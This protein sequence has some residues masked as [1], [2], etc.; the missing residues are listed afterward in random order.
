MEGRGAGG[1]AGFFFMCSPESSAFQNYEQQ[2]EFLTAMISQHISDFL[3]DDFTQLLNSDP[4][5]FLE[6]LGVGKVNGGPEDIVYVENSRKIFGYEIDPR[7][8]FSSHINSPKVFFFRPLISSQI[9][10]L[11]FPV[12]EAEPHSGHL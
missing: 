1:R 7:A 11:H 6:F 3:S 12:L 8:F 9:A 4:R 2:K 5:R 10:P